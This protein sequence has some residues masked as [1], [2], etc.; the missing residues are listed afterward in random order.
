[1]HQKTKLSNEPPTDIDES[2]VIID[3]AKG[4]KDKGSSS[5][6]ALPSENSS[7]LI[8]SNKEDADSIKELSKVNVSL[9]EEASI[10]ANSIQVDSELKKH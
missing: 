7:H 1:M 5:L 4:R 3:S 6:N 2:A 8:G 10:A 9:R